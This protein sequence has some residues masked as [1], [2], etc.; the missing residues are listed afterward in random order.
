MS[1]LDK[2][3]SQL[4]G[5]GREQIQD[6]T[7]RAESLQRGL[8]G[9]DLG[10][11]S[12]PQS[13]RLAER[14]ARQQVQGATEEQAR[15]E[16]I[17]SEQLRLAE[18]AQEQAFSDQQLGQIEQAM[19]AKQQAA[20]QSE[21]ILNELEREG[22]KLDLQKDAARLE[23]IGFNLRMNNKQYIDNLNRSG[24]TSRLEDAIRFEEELKRAIFDDQIDLL[25][26][27]L[28]FRRLVDADERE[29]ARELSTISLQQAME[30]ASMQA[31]QINQTAKYNAIGQV[32]KGGAQAYAA[33]EDE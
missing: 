25:N 19:S 5:T 10:P 1:L 8:T 27:D 11:S 14:I 16:D 31:E 17:Q 30:I 9:R 21:A 2:L 12:S 20:Q 6:E 29:L 32:V 24:K 15:K 28:S 33:Y 13:S 26:N 22:R 7:A 18:E 23:Q 4:G 3:R